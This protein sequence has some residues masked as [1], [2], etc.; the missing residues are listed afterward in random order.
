MP[1]M[2]TVAPRLG[3][4]GEPGGVEGAVQDVAAPD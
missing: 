3:D 2:E 1:G 4:G